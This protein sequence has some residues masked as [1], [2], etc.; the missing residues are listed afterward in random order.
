MRKSMIVAVLMGAAASAPAYAQWARPYED[1][2]YGYGYN[3]NGYNNRDD[4]AYGIDQQIRQVRTE[5]SSAA[6]QDRISYDREQR[7]LQQL[8]D[9]SDRYYRYRDNGM[10]SSER[11]DV[12]DRLGAIQNDVRSGDGWNE[13]S[14]DGE[15]DGYSDDNSR[16]REDNDEG[17]GY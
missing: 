11:Q 5:I 14:Q 1:T 4:D 12:L 15:D 3:D 13:R 6:D 7:L 10:S 2:G 9:I 17:D 8:N 16:Y